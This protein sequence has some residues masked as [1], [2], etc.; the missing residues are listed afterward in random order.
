MPAAQGMQH[1]EQALLQ[2]AAM[3]A[4]LKQGSRDAL[5]LAAGATPEATRKAFLELTKQYHPNRFARFSAATQRRANTVF[6]AIKRAHDD[7]M[8]G[9]RGASSLPPPREGAAGERPSLA[10]VLR[11]GTPSMAPPTGR[12]S[13]PMPHPSQPIEVAAAARSRR[14]SAVPQWLPHGTRARTTS[15]PQPQGQ[16][17]SGAAPSRPSVQVA[18][19]PTAVTAPP[20]AATSTAQPGPGTSKAATP[21]AK[22]V[23]PKSPEDVKFDAAKLA[24]NQQRWTD[25]DVLLGELAVAQPMEK[26]FRVFRHFVRG[27]QAQEENRIAD[28]RQEYERALSLD[29]TFASARIALG[30]LPA[31]GFLG[32]LFKR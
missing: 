24:I 1:E 12:P 5:G 19:T 13:G 7:L 23:A 14:P 10:S 27:R 22:A 21:T 29:A 2:L 9:A 20:K 11:T 28:A 31:P 15:S 8:K 25:A 6:V 26:K 32:R 17:Q 16:P 4:K 30:Q 3:E 18:T